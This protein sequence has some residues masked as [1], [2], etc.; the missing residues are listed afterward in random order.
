[1]RTEAYARAAALHAAGVEAANDMRPTAGARRLRQA[2]ALLAAVDDP[3]AVQLR[4][5]VLVSLAYSVAEQGDTDLGLRHL[6]EAESLLP[7]SERGVLHGQRAVL[8]R[9]TGRDDEALAEYDRAL[10]VVDER[11][12]PRELARVLLNRGVLHLRAS[13]PPAARADLARA[14]RVARRHGLTLIATKAGHNLALLDLAAGD[15]PRAL[16]AFNN[17]AQEYAREAP[18]V[19]PLLALDRARVLLAAGLYREADEELA[20]AAA[21]LRTQGMSQDDGEALLARAEAALLAG[22]PAAA[23]RWAAE[24][25]ATFD[26]RKNGRFWELAELVGA[27]ASAAEGAPSARLLRRLTGLA[28]RLAALGLDED[29]RVAGLL[30]ARC[31]A[32][33]GRDGEARTLLSAYGRRRRGDRLDTRVLGR[34]VRA[35]V[36]GTRRELADGLAELHRYRAA[37]GCLDLQTGA[38]VH[39]RDLAA[40]GVRHALSDGRA[41]T[42]FRWA[43]R[44][45]AQALLL[46]AVRP[47][48][49]PEAAAAVERLR[50]LRLST[51]EAERA[52]RPTAALRALCAELERRIRQRSWASPGAGGVTEP[53]ALRDAAAA[54]GDAAMVV[55][56]RD[57]P[58][59]H[60]LILQNGRAR[61]AVLGS[62]AAAEE[63]VLRLRADLDALAGRALPER[64]ATAI[65]AALR[66][67]A[68]ALADVV[69]APVL[70]VV[71][72]RPLVLVP[73]GGL[74]VAPWSLLPGCAGR[75]V[76]VTPSA[77]T[78]YAA[79]SRIGAAPGRSS[80]PVPGEGP[81]TLVAGPGNDRAEAEI[82][83][84]AALYP[85]SAV[86]TGS[87]ATAGAT[88]AAMSG[89]GLVHVA[90]HGRHQAQNPLFSSFELAD[91]PLMGYDLQQ[92]AAP[93]RRAVLSTCDLGLADVRPGDESIGLTTALIA[94]GTV[95]VVA[96]VGRVADDVAMRVMT[97]LHRHLAAG[98][99][100]AAALAAATGG[101]PTGFVCFGAGD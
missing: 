88:A 12:E 7:P 48:H 64:L 73:T 42:V 46:P 74:M 50:Q 22:R 67:D 23:G 4:G 27:R 95:T 94:A 66:R 70:P 59:L 77:T 98:G 19:L 28:D 17:I 85:G 72:D 26:R 99:T 40:A 76:T 43:E 58:T 52:G 91:G 54:L 3:E 57:G 11:R 49:D 101:E 61:L 51:G 62:A 44:S 87:G 14:A 33:L 90:A 78:W 37:F 81:V 32:G 41:A 10:A 53:V 75:P 47:P 56:L 8:L 60:A 29:A 2:L 92:L 30:A 79:R 100:P 45:R 25:R 13:R 1:M 39:G 5:R 69:L 24:A 38:A 89:A 93:P 68:E 6:D 31:A 15:L 55:Y 80:R 96:S 35:E 63:S 71:G 36:T 65:L 20:G 82:R 83:E 34:L 16:S 97:D 84:I 21:A 86:L 18:G 9:R